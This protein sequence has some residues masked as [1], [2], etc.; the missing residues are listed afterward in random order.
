MYIDDAIRITKPEPDSHFRLLP[1]R[2]CKGD[3]VA[4]VQYLDKDRVL[5]RVSCFD[6]GFTVKPEDAACAH[7]AQLAW[8]G[9]VGTA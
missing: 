6:C 3:N 8:N 7:D 5:Y 4:Y 1:C 2:Q 9:E